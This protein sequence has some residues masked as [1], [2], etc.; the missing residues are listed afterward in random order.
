MPGK[1]H[2]D[3]VVALL[4][5]LRIDHAGFVDAPADDLDRLLHRALRPRVQRHR[6]QGQQ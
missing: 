5:D 6:R 1:L 4:G 2:D 3:A